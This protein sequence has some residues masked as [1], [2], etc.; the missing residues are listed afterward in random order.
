MQIGI[1]LSLTAPRPGTGVGAPGGAEIVLTEGV[2]HYGDSM[3]EGS[4]GG[5]AE[6][7]YNAF[8]PTLTRYM[9]AMGLPTAAL[10]S[11]V[12]GESSTQALTRWLARSTHYRYN[13]WWA[14]RN[15]ISV[16]ATPIANAAAAVADLA[17]GE[18]LLIFSVHPINDGTENSG[19]TN[20]NKILEINAGLAAL[21]N[22]TTVF[23]VDTLAEFMF[24]GALDHSPDTTATGNGC[25][26]VTLT[27]DGLH[28]NS[29][30]YDVVARTVFRRIYDHW[31]IGNPRANLVINGEFASDVSGWSNLNSANPSWSSGELVIAAGG[32]PWKATGQQLLNSGA[33]GKR[34]MLRYDITDQAFAN[35]LVR[36]EPYTGGGG[37]YSAASGFGNP[38]NYGYS[39]GFE[40]AAVAS[41]RRR[42]RNVTIVATANDV[43]LAVLFT[44]NNDAGM[45]ITIDNVVVHEVG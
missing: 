28:P 9:S 17:P 13:I 10:N 4:S 18:V 29:L 3:A 20:H 5:G 40:T 39:V 7:A 12:G 38:L 36:L 33:N 44:A 11:A 43:A 6:N 31:L 34:Y 14:G 21:A 8:R 37:A 42:G 25:P 30:G 45:G 1:L 26:A 24:A 23:Y 41:A 22:G 16:P 15:D 35:W 19:S 2:A 32:D 27:A